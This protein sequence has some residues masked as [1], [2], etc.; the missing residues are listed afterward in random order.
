M[1][2]NP[3]FPGLGGRS[4]QSIIIDTECIHWTDRHAHTAAIAQIH[5]DL[6]TAHV[7][8]T[9]G[10]VA[11]MSDTGL[12][13]DVIPGNADVTVHRCFAYIRDY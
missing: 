4:H 7:G 9:D 2:W 12:T 5:I 6:S 10:L 11:A 3:S 13:D 1:P 8:C